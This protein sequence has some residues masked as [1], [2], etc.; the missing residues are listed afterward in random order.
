MYAIELRHQLV[1]YFQHRVK[2]PITAEEYIRYE[3]PPPAKDPNADRLKC[4][5]ETL[6]PEERRTNVLEVDEIEVISKKVTMSTENTDMSED[7]E[8]TEPIDV[9]ED[10]VYAKRHDEDMA[11]GDWNQLGKTQ[12]AKSNQE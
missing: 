2:Y 10:A 9:E 7:D 12:K 6:T 1:Y 5:E 8:A 11:K 4:P 3:A